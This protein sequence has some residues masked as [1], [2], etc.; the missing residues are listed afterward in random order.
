MSEGLEGF[1]LSGLSLLE[2][3]LDEDADLTTHVD[4]RSERAVL[5]LAGSEAAD[6]HV[7]AHDVNHLGA[8][9]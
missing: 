4:V 8:S 5:S 6:L 7:L 3:E 1:S 9:E 2:G